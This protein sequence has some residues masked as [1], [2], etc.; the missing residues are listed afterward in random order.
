MAEKK[1]AKKYKKKQQNNIIDLDELLNEEGVN[2]EKDPKDEDEKLD[3]NSIKVVV[4]R[5]EHGLIGSLRIENDR[6]HPMFKPNDIVHLRT[7]SKITIGDF[8]L[9]QSHDEYFLRRIIKYKDD[10]IYVAGDNEKEYHIIKKEDI[11]GRAIARERKNKYLSLSLKNT[12]SFYN[13]RKVNLASMRLGSRVLDYEGEINNE[14]LENAMQHIQETQTQEKPKEYKY[15]IDLDS[16]LAAFLNPDVLVDQLEE[17]RAEEEAA[18]L[19]AQE[20]YE[21]EYEEYED[22][23]YEESVGEESVGEESVGEESVGEEDTSE[24]DEELEPQDESAE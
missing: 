24:D 13:F 10:N 16:D 17:A 12:K 7:Q 18:R 4:E 8:V 23:E 1:Q 15:N 19:E 5:V 14:A 11:I 22:G 21:E 6:N 3:V 9:Y 20:E 2:Q